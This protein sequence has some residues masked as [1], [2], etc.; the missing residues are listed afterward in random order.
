MTREDPGGSTA[1]EPLLDLPLRAGE[2]DLFD[3]PAPPIPQPVHG[4]D[5]ASGA[6]PLSRRWLA[7]GADAAVVCL[8]I[9]AAGLSASALRG[10]LVSAAALAWAA[11]FALYLS[12]FATVL[13]LVLFSRTLGMALADLTARAP[14][15]PRIRSGEG[16]RRWVG[17]LA[18]LAGLGIPLLFTRSDREAPSLADRISGRPLV[19][20][21][22]G[23]RS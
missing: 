23:D 3:P 7:M 5:P 1:E 15:A 6:V 13:P 12:F 17:T 4:A 2:G 19:E 21:E 9:A 11:A 14:G 20:S 16:A 10:G 18:T 8:I 22:R